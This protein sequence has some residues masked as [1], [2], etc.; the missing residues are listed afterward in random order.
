MLKTLLAGLLPALALA[1][2]AACAGDDPTP[3]PTG[4]PPIRSATPSPGPT[5]PEP[6]GVVVTFLVAGREE[7]RILLTDAA[8]IAIARRLLAGDTAP[9]IPN[10]LVLRDGPGENLGYSWHI[11]PESVEFADLAIEVCDGL[12][13]DVEKA[14]STSDHYCPWAAKVIAIDPA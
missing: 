6:A 3:A 4:A 5:T 7:Y 10:G 2:A 14:A 11:D 12:P 8:D 1:V 13:S 9:A